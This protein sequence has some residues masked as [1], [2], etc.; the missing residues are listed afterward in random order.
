M[1]SFLRAT[2]L[3]VALSTAGSGCV[4]VH[5]HERSGLERTCD[6]D[7]KDCDDGTLALLAIGG[8]IAVAGAV[9][10]VG[11][12]IDL[13]ALPFMKKGEGFAITKTIFGAKKDHHCDADQGVPPQPP[14]SP[15]EK[16]WTEPARK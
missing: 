6:D 13:I 15:V 1:S 16:E 10:I 2:A 3:A 9:V 4:A 12:V 14:K 8:I 5:D 7:K 11:F